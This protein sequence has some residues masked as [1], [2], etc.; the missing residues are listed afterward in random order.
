MSCCMDEKIDVANEVVKCFAPGTSL[1]I[2]S[3]HVLVSW[4]DSFGKYERRWM[5]RGQDFYPVCIGN[6]GTAEQHP[7]HYPSLFVGCA[8]KA[9][10]R[11]PRGDTGPGTDIGCCDKG[12]QIRQ[13]NCLKKL[14]IQS[15][16]NAVCA[17]ANWN[18]D[19][20]GGILMEYPGHAAE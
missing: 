2:E 16:R 13:L 4:E 9:Y 18:R 11:C 17:A 20:I 15:V 1:R 3:G 5:T 7:R 6:G 14:G 10:C 8:G 19:S 12:T